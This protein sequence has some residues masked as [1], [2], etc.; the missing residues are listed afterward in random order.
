MMDKIIAEKFDFSRVKGISMNQL[1]Q[2]YKIYE[3]YVKKTNEIWKKTDE[4]IDFSGTNP[5]YSPIRSLMLGQSYAVDGVKLHKLYFENIC[6]YGR[7]ISGEIYKLIKRDFNSYERWEKF[8]ASAGMSMRG[9]VVLGVD[10]IDNRLHIYGL[11]AHD[12]GAIWCCCPLLIMDVYEHAYM[13][14]F[15]IDR[16]KYI[17]VFMENINWNIV[18]ER[19]K[20]YKI[21]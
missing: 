21:I 14:D 19:L 9:W 20:N 12:V 15:G 13:I 1:S 18:N 17:E 7:G 4:I 2:H 8:F 11:D 10:K 6:G 5:T 16:K 3:G